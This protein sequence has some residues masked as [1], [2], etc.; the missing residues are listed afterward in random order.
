MRF[1]LELKELKRL[2]TRSR[3]AVGAASAPDVH[4]HV[5]LCVDA[6]GQVT[7]TATDGGL[8]AFV[9][10][11]GADTEPGEA[12]V[13]FSDLAMASKLKGARTSTTAELVGDEVWIDH[14]DSD[15]RLTVRTASSWVPIPIPLPTGPPVDLPALA[16]C[17]GAAT[18][19]D[20][21][22]P[23]GVF[24]G[25]DQVVATDGF[26]LSAVAGH[27]CDAG[28]VTLPPSLVKAAVRAKAPA[29]LAVD[30]GQVQLDAQEASYQAAAAGDDYPDWRHLL[31]DGDVP[32]L[33]GVSTAELS[34]LAE[35][36]T[37]QANRERLAPTMV[38]HHGEP[39]R[40]TLQLDEQLEVTLDGSSPG[41]LAV[42]PEQLKALLAEM[43]A[44]ELLIPEPVTGQTGGLLIAR[45]QQADATWLRLLQQHVCAVDDR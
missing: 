36:W 19:G 33:T 4:K 12:V 9:T 31:P 39:V 8:A 21:Q 32:Q 29:H 23:A 13:L 2:I 45:E 44:P 16:F 38:I 18:D 35:T 43:T 37:K 7:V 11:D 17:I 27:G 22:A 1:T 42:A 25:P 14:P 40:C 5:H 3:P 26:L 20:D 15:T 28:P 24:V 6:D 30:D 41:D 34:D 10:A